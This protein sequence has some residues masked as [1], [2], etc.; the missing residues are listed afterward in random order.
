[1]PVPRR[2]RRG[3]TRSPASTP[4]SA[5]TSART[6]DRGLTSA[7]P[8]FLFIGGKGGVGK[9]TCAA[10][11]A[12]A[13][14]A[15]GR[16]T[17]VISTDPAPSLGDALARPLGRS[18]RKIPIARHWLHAVEIDAPRALERW[19]AGR[20]DALERIAARGTWLDQEDV[21]R[22]LRLSLPG[23]DELAALIEIARLAATGQYDLVVVDTAP[24]GHTLR[25]LS[26]PGTFRAIAGVF[27]AMQ[28]KHRV[29]VEALRGGWMP[30]AEDAL[31]AAIDR[32]GQDLA[33]LLRDPAKVRLSWVTLPEPMAIE[34]T[35]DAA[36]ALASAGIPL[37]SIIVNRITPR[38]DR[39]CGWCDARRVLEPRAIGELTRRLPGLPLAL[40]AARR[41]EPRGARALAGIGAELGFFSARG[42]AG[43]TAAPPSPRAGKAAT[44]RPKPPAGEGVPLDRF[45]SEGTRLIV[46]G[47]KGGV[48]KTT[49]AAALAIAIAVQRPAAR[50]L[51]MSTDPAHSLADVFGV[52]L[53]D[54]P[55]TVTGAPRNL[56]AREIDAAASFRD[57][58]DRYAAAIDTLFERLS[59]GS[60]SGVGV[61]AGHDRE[62]MQRLIDL[63]P[64]GVDELAAVIDV[65]D[66]LEGEHGRRSFDLVVMDTA[67]SGHALRL[68]QMPALVQGWARALMSIVL[69]YQA[70]AGVG[71]LGAVLLKLSQ[72]LGRLRALLADPD[73]TSFVAVTR[74]A[75]L[76]RSE[77]VRLIAALGRLNVHVP[78]IVVN[79]VGRGP[80]SRCR[81]A[82]VA[83]AR[84]IASLRRSAGRSRHVVMAPAE[85]PP[86]HGVATLR[87]WQKTWRERVDP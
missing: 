51:L 12:A 26:M 1:V 2:S 78:A 18:P 74:G 48:G 60:S 84:E 41:T 7:G 72:G 38:P 37:R 29:M 3:T 57:V 39:P 46:F 4:R 19:L 71:E 20:R 42:P 50:V 35:A 75:A 73:R 6:S 56:A 24:T 59:R 66:A 22:L 55:R 11:A 25:M 49:C 13:W 70:V 16:R 58:R 80:C 47:G 53:S 64:P 40:V 61:D 21:S 14:A 15:R 8:D 33:A 79:A 63:A 34:E 31:I 87:R 67:P 9:T 17:L 30:D 44:W 23:I 65:T 52:P 81:S 86:P 82:A 69:K 85:L 83:E 10:A 43:L 36:A 45:L 68:L 28:A 76:P 62:V 32:E 27:D 5:A 54:A 77:T